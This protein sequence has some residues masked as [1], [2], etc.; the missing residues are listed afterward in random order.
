MLATYELL[1][2]N[3]LEPVSE[4]VTLTPHARMRSE[5]CESSWKELSLNMILMEG[6]RKAA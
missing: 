1:V 5:C 6:D 3:E 4:A 2:I